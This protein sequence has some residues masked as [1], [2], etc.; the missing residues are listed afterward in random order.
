MR[1]EYGL[2]HMTCAGQTSWFG[3]AQEFLGWV[4]ARCPQRKLA[5]C[6]PISSAEYPLPARRPHNSVLS[7]EKLRRTFGLKLLDWREAVIQVMEELS[8]GTE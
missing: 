3:F 6:V 7:N 5:R 2:Y 8:L 1:P 4:A